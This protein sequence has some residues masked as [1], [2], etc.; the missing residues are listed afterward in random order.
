VQLQHELNTN[1]YKL[2]HYEE[3]TKYRDQLKENE[4]ELGLQEQ[5]E[6]QNLN[7][8]NDNENNSIKGTDMILMES[9]YQQ[10]IE[11]LNTNHQKRIEEL[12]AQLLNNNQEPEGHQD[13]IEQL[14]ESHN[15]QIE[16]QRSTLLQEHS[17]EIA[18][19]VK[20]QQLQTDMQFAELNKK[21]QLLEQSQEESNKTIELKQ[22]EILELEYKI[23]S[24]S[25]QHAIE[26]ASNQ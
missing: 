2:K 5:K 26:I 14:K 12:Q 17:K 25:D 20:N 18:E 7:E 24:N 15:Q 1:E 4:K 21:I 22:K 16:L 13:C 3:M 19:I 9:K 10:E 8:N 23:K 11:Q 6:E